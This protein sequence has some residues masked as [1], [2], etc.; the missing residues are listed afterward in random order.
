MS[1][2]VKRT[3]LGKLWRLMFVKLPLAFFALTFLWV[4]IL[5]WCPVYVTPLMIQRSIEYRGDKGF[6]TRKTWTPYEKISPEMA[7]AVIASEDN[8]FDKHIGFD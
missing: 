2:K 7:R 6:H 1:R 8:L 5:K 4:L 3:F